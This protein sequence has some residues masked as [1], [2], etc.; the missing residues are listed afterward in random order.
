M[1]ESYEIGIA[2]ALDNGVSAGIAAI[3]QDLATLDRAVASSA[4]GLLTLRRLS[5]GLSGNAP[6]PLPPFTQ[7]SP[8]LPA[9]TEL[10]TEIHAS[11]PP[12]VL[13]P[14]PLPAPI[15]AT[16]I[17]SAPS[18]PWANDTPADAVRPPPPQPVITAALSAQPPSQPMPVPPVAAIATVASVVPKP[19]IPPHLPNRIAAA[20]FSEPKAASP[21]PIRLPA[22]KPMPIP[23]APTFAPH[24][25]TPYRAGQIH[26]TPA[27]PLPPPPAP[28]HPEPPTNNHFAP[29]AV[30]PAAAAAAASR[31]TRADRTEPLS[32]QPRA[33]DAS[34]SAPD[35]DT[36]SHGEII[37]DSARLGRWISDRLARAADRP[38][39]GTTGFDPRVSPSYAGAPN[40]S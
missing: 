12:S 20:N 14:W 30:R 38:Q 28:D 39:S 22:S 26:L 7:P 40:G 25:A 36:A 37:L 23:D 16:L 33:S 9:P 27:A 31:P 5:E 13:A 8:V 17:D 32:L 3:R 2:L 15:P 19:S 6:G 10:A 29:M 24:P 4:A 11:P 35:S 18:A 1:I 21:G 34:G